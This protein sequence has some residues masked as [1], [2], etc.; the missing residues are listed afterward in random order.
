MLRIGWRRIEAV[1]TALTRNQVA[2]HGAR[3]FESHRL[4]HIINNGW[5]NKTRLVMRRVLLCLCPKSLIYRT[6]SGIQG[7]CVCRSEWLPGGFFTY[8]AFC[9]NG[10]QP[11]W[12]RVLESFDC[13]KKRSQVQDDSRG[14]GHIS[15][16]RMQRGHEIN[17]LCVFYKISSEENKSSL[18]FSFCVYMG[19]SPWPEVEWARSIF[20]RHQMQRVQEM[21]VRFKG[22][23]ENF[24]STLRRTPA[25]LHSSPC[26]Q[27]FCRS[28][29]Q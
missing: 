15:V 14:S 17:V 22:N 26:R 29:L 25:V 23:L 10:Q 1:I 19:I 2:P 7:S 24:I 28:R 5:Y 9:L 6:F 8:R 27:W 11:I 16:N 20:L 21:S 13:L 12:N 18:Y 4:R 3:G